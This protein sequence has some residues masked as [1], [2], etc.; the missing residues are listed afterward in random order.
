[1][2]VLLLAIAAGAAVA[3]VRTGRVPNVLTYG[4]ALAGIVLN[5]ALRPA[6]LGLGPSL[7]GLAVG[8]VP[9]F[10]AYLAGG[11][12][13]G[14]VKLMAAAGAFLGPWYAA[15][16]L[17]YSCLAGAVLSVGLILWREGF[18]G[19]FMRIGSLWRV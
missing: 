10:V 14:D 9:L 6:G 4:A 8:F 1:M 12:G 19:I 17:L 16:A 7:A 18:T 15:H 3:D 13:G 5:A 2:D 11:I